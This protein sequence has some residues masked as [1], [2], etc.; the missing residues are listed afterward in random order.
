V[1]AKVVQRG[2][3]LRRDNDLCREAKNVYLFEGEGPETV[4]G[5]KPNEVEVPRVIGSTLADA[6]ERLALQPLDYDVIYKPA[7]RGQRLDIVLGQIPK[8]G[9]LSAYDKVMLVLA[10]PKHGVVPNV[11][12]LSVPAAI[13]RL[14]RKDLQPAVVGPMRGTVIK[15]TPRRVAAA[16]GLRVRLISAR[17]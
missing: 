6:K 5:C 4:A 7:K 14:E 2:G 13:R 10:K 9:T 11:V 3:K 16:P 15:Q 8:R 1:P 12:G 17:G